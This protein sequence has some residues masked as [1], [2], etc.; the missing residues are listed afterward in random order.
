MNNNIEFL[1]KRVDGFLNYYGK[2]DRKSICSFFDIDYRTYYR[3]RSI[4]KK[5]RSNL[6]K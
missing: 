5:R 2:I 6:P 1:I 3:L 4:I